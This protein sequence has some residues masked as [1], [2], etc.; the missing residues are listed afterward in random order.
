MVLGF[1]EARIV[2]RKDLRGRRIG[3]GDHRMDIVVL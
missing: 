2:E 1:G 3:G